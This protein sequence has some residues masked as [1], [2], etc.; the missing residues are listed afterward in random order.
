MP[1]RLSL[2]CLVAFSTSV[3]SSA[4]N[5]GEAGA[6]PEEFKPQGQQALLQKT[7]KSTGPQMLLEDVA[8]PSANASH[9]ARSQ[10]S[11]SQFS[12]PSAS[13]PRR[14]VGINPSG[15]A[16]PLTE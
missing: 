9:V 3:Q 13:S 12:L 6:F 7:Q 5:G 2:L 8:L 16:A 1:S 10:L 11:K 4:L 14:K 15:A